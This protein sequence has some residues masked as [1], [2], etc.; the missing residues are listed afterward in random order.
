M[1]SSH[2]LD[3][4][5]SVPV[6]KAPPREVTCIN[7]RSDNGSEMEDGR[8]HCPVRAIGKG[9]DIHI[10]PPHYEIAE[11]VHGGAARRGEALASTQFGPQQRD[12]KSSTLH[13]DGFR[14]HHKMT[15]IPTGDRVP[16]GLWY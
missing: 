8:W 2:S 12:E 13:L 9:R 6:P 16:L 1:Q 7:M 11:H 3:E 15:R 5:K 14:V 10:S 4:T